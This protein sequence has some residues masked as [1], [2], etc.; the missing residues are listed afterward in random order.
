MRSLQL[1]SWGRII[2]KISCYCIDS[3]R[4][5]L[6]GFGYKS[7]SCNILESFEKFMG[8]WMLMNFFT[9]DFNGFKLYRFALGVRF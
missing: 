4:R 1:I 9:W 3:K 5:G 8:F 2:L 7:I 6:F